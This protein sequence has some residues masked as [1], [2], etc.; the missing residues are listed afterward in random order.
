MNARKLDGITFSTE[1]GGTDVLYDMDSRLKNG[2][3]SDFLDIRLNKDGT[4]NANSKKKILSFSDGEKLVSKVK[5]IAE[6]YDNEIRSGVIKQ[7]PYKE[8]KEVTACR[9]CDY[10][11]ICGIFDKIEGREPDKTKTIDGEK[12]ADK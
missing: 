3:E 6:D 5:K 10:A 8:A 7:N 11:Q 4:F 9:Y 1:N 2:E 12:G